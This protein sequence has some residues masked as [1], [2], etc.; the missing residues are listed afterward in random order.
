MIAYNPTSLDNL[1][2]QEQA[3]QALAAGCITGEEQ[4][5]IRASYPEDLYTPNIFLCIGLFLL[6]VV[7]IAFS[8]GLIL[9]VTA[10]GSNS[11]APVLLFAALVCYGTL[12]FVV[13]NK[14]HFRSGVD[15]ALLWTS[16]GLFYAGLYFLH[17][18]MPAV[19]QC[20]I[21]FTLALIFTLRFANNI[22][23]VVAYA[24]L[25]GIIFNAASQSG[26]TARAVLP[27]LVMAV[28]GVVYFIA[29]GLTASET[30][31]HYRQCLSV[32]KAAT[33]L[34]FYLAGNYFVVRELNNYLLG[35]S[36]QA[37]D[38]F[39]PASGSSPQASAGIPLGWLFWTLTAL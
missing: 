14:R 24:A 28:S 18:N 3:G 12:E 37:S 19:S 27:F 36:A 30:C 34:S 20:L 1:D 26:A 15:Y 29:N 31:R 23:T 9:L 2:I 4:A 33:L 38:S 16:A 6:S 10:G 7:I 35:S 21:V 13:Y 22:M 39:G 17:D 11:I 8:L 32:L 5:K 25:L